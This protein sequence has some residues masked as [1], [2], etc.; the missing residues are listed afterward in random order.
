[1]L[2]F[3]WFE[4][5]RLKLKVWNMPKAKQSEKPTFQCQ[6]DPVCG[7]S[8]QS[9]SCFASTYLHS[10]RMQILVEYQWIYWLVAEQLSVSW[11]PNKL[12][13][14]DISALLYTVLQ[15]VCNKAA[16]EHSIYSWR[17]EKPDVVFRNNSTVL[18]GVLSPSNSTAKLVWRSA[19]GKV[20]H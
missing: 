20:T 18:G 7:A 3:S 13:Y 10:L 8:I 5:T 1:M 6:A 16:C 9:Q 14:D 4:W 15:R 2:T 11:T 12:Q 17:C 19:N